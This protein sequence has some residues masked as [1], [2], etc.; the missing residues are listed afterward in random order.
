MNYTQEL[1][2]IY[3]L[4]FDRYGPQHWWPGET[5]D[6]IIIGAILTQNTNWKNV[7]KAIENLKIKNL[8]TL[9]N[10]T[11]TDM[12]E[13]TQCI[14]PS[15]YYNQKA[16][17]LQEIAQYF[18][19]SDVQSFSTRTTAEM[20]TELLALKGIGPETADSILL[21]A[22]EKPVF[23]IDT[24]T[25]R[26]FARSG[27]FPGNISYDEAQNFFMQNLQE[28][29]ELFNEFHALL[30]RHAKECCQKNPHCIKCVLLKKCKFNNYDLNQEQ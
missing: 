22:F 11:K 6:E 3:D 16:L 9:V 12:P 18:M 29:A 4:L 21:Y 15:G 1:V 14:R 7:E 23:V 25:K 8:L 10:I 13:I 28:N 17:R 2:E 27:I 5:R 19:G 20:R 26:I 24:Y 30:V